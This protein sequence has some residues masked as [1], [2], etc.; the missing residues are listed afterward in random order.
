MAR[1]CL[2]LGSQRKATYELSLESFHFFRK[3]LSDEK[4]SSRKVNFEILKIPVTIEQCN[5][6]YPFERNSP[7]K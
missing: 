4:S 3:T 5:K 1:N 2:M 6:Q 7:V